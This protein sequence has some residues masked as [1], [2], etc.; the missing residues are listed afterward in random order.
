MT[1]SPGRGGRQVIPRPDSAVEGPPSPWADLPVAQRRPSVA[2]VVRGLREGPPPGPSRWEPLE[3]ARRSAVLVP[4][5]DEDGLAHVILTRRAWHLRNHKGEISFPG[6]RQEDDEDLVDTALREAGEEI[7]LD[8][9]AVEI[10]GQLDHM[11]TFVSNSTIVPYVGVLPTRP[12]ILV[13]NPE[14]V[15]AVVIVP[16]A[17]LLQDG[18]HRTER[19]AFPGQ[20]GIAGDRPMHFFELVGDTVW[21][22]TARMLMNLLTRTLGLEHPG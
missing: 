11:A 18:V 20:T 22:A 16:L 7:A 4:L 6:G 1:A 10:V 21:G 8:V 3:G 5:F 2:D 19:W 12:A 13:P 17:E 9:D 15:E 14:E